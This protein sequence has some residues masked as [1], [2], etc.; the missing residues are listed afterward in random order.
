MLHRPTAQL[1]GLLLS[2]PPLATESNRNPAVGLWTA[3]LSAAA[4]CVAV[5]PVNC[6]INIA[7]KRTPSTT[8]Q[9]SCIPDAHFPEAAPWRLLGLPT[10]CIVTF[11]QAFGLCLDFNHGGW[12]SSLS[13]LPSP[14]RATKD[15][16]YSVPIDQVQ[17]EPSAVLLLDLGLTASLSKFS[18]TI[19]IWKILSSCHKPL[20]CMVVTRVFGIKK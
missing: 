8:H 3:H 1:S 18:G 4:F 13:C 19:Q 2:H 6:H 7:N 11:T 20:K 5:S 16:N 9:G 12:P 10:L 15:N 14:E 17:G